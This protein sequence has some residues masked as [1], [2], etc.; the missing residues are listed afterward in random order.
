MTGPL[1][2]MAAA[3]FAGHAIIWAHLPKAIAGQAAGISHGALLVAGGSSFDKPPWDGGVKYWSHDIYVYPPSEKHPRRFVLDR[4]LAYGCSVSWHDMLILAGGS[5]GKENFARVQTLEWKDNQVAQHDLPPLPHG[6]SN[7][8][9]ALLENTLYIFG[10][11]ER[12]DSEHASTALYS[13][14]LSH[15]AEGW[16]VREPLPAEGRILPVF[17]SVGDAL[18]LF[19]GA[20]L[21]PG[22]RRYLED[23]WRYHSD[24]G[25]K[26][27]ADAPHPMVAAPS[28]VQGRTLWIFGGDDGRLASQI[29]VLKDEHPGFSKTVLAFQS[30]T[31][32]WRTL[33]VLPVSLVTTAACA[34]GETVYL[35]GG[36]DRPGH[37]SSQI[38]QWRLPE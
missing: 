21:H 37:R 5:D 15:P 24:S 16:R 38:L 1:L 23:G 28:V 32:T 36:E 9:A 13:L 6:L 33:G 7:C 25:W 14:N 30:E 26:K 3:M 18:Y 29:N 27:I 11:Q 35:P 4:P 20:V 8:G 19:S 22:G 10:G 12:P 31:Q 34:L 2:I 17:A